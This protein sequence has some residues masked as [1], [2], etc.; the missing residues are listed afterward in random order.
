MQA[1]Q[2]A[3]TS[4]MHTRNIVKKQNKHI[5]PSDINTSQC[6]PVAAAITFGEQNKVWKASLLGI[7]WP[8]P[9]TF[10]L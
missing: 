3:K 9:E 5:I 7:I 10:A 1:V 6:F 2:G 8:L 4:I